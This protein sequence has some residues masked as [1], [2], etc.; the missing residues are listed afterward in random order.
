MSKN[1]IPKEFENDEMFKKV[2]G[3]FQGEQNEE[4]LGQTLEK[5]METLLSPKVLKEP[6]IQ[7][8]SKY[9]E[10]LKANKT[11]IS[12]Q[13]YNK[14]YQQYE[15]ACKIVQVY[16]SDPNNVMKL[17]DLM[18]EMQ[19]LGSPPQEI[20]DQ[21]SVDGSNVPQLPDMDKCPMQ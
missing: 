18:K 21:L 4:K 17:V 3:L 15:Y 9:P 20:L 13:E 12:E 11:K 19:E 6:M 7:L 5:I 1:E 16:E 10:W 8:K 2:W 14:V